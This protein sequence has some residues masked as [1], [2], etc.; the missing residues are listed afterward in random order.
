MT[1]PV[2]SRWRILKSTHVQAETA[3]T[4]GTFDS[5]QGSYNYF[6]WL[7]VH[8]HLLSSISTGV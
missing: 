8:L 7:F 5:D 4:H 2:A 3:L 1:F 6:M